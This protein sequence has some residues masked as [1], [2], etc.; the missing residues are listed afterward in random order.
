[1]RTV[2]ALFLLVGGVMMFQGCGSGQSGGS[3]SKFDAGACN[4]AYCVALGTGTACCTTSG[5]CGTD[6]GN[7][8]VASGLSQVDGGH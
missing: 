2:A 8:C 4:P 5:Q 7:G 1:M 3:F 6:F